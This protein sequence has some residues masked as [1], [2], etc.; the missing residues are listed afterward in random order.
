[1][2][3]EPQYDD[4]VQDVATFLQDR[5]ETLLQAKVK[6]ER[7][8]I[9]PGLGFGKNLAHNLCLLQN[10]QQLIQ[11]LALPMLIGLSRKSMVGALTGKGID[12][13]MAGSL[14]GMLMAVERGAM[15]V[16]VHDVAETVDAC[17]VWH[18]VK[19]ASC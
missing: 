4:V 9:D 16:R 13:R 8:C 19:M 17:R 3:Q 7:L 15:I 2:Q 1:M 18:A 11:T 6:R 10:T 14:A 5:I 12:G